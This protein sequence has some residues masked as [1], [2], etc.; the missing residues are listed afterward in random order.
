[1]STEKFNDVEPL[2]V[3]DTHAEVDRKLG[4]IFIA[5]GST[6]EPAILTVDHARALYEWL[7]KALPEESK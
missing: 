3:G 1:M 6:Y 2:R 4:T 7:G 5:D